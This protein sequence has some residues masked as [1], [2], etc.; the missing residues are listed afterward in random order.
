MSPLKLYWLKIGIEI[1]REEELLRQI[2][3]SPVR[4]SMRTAIFGGT[5]DPIH[6]AH[7]EMAR[8]AADLSA[9]SRSVHPGRAIRRT[10]T[11]T[12]PLRTATA[13]WNWPARRPALRC[14]AARR[15]R[16]EELLDS[17]HRAREGRER[18]KLFF[19]IGADAFA[20]IETWHRWE[21][22]IRA[23][24]FIVVA[25]PGHQIPESARRARASLETVELP[26][27]S[28]EIR[29]AWRGEN[30]GR[31]CRR[32]SRITSALHGLVSAS[33]RSSDRGR[34]QIRDRGQR[35][36]IRRFRELADDL[37]GFFGERLGAFLRAL[38]PV[39]AVEDVE[40]LAERNLIVVA[41]GQHGFDQ[42][43]LL[44]RRPFPARRSA[45]A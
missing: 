36:L 17:H 9:R 26:V 1:E 18:A 5:F 41:V 7:L 4:K 30:A 42:L 8:Q 44:R 23:V 3:A 25:R 45:A 39:M 16:R 38:D 24:E 13:W 21:D 28:S 12:R 34:D 19:I 2:A 43:A 27:S 32:R 6:S 22:V 29:E 40:N 31:I 33:K 20:E 11:P 10:S 37:A 35:R 15:R 14:L